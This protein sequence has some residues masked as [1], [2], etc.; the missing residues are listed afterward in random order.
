M[1]SSTGA[2]FDNASSKSR[3][4]PHKIIRNLS[5]PYILKC[6]NAFLLSKREEQKLQQMTHFA[7][8]TA[9]LLALLEIMLLLFPYTFWRSCLWKLCGKDPKVCLQLVCVSVNCEFACECETDKLTS[10]S[11]KLFSFFLFVRTS[12]VRSTRHPHHRHLLF[13]RL[14]V[15]CPPFFSSFLVI[16]AKY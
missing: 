8:W 14:L 11:V 4:Y 6:R 7:M 3:T 13:V 15:P 9:F 2:T 16:L 5:I 12:S 10:F 1:P